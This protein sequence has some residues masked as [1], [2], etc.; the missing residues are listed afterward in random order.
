MDEHALEQLWLLRGAG[1]GDADAPV[2]HAARPFRGLR[3]VAELFFGVEHHDDRLR[4]I[5][6]EHL[7]NSPE[8]VFE[9]PRGLGGERPVDMA[10]KHHSESIDTPFYEAAIGLSIG[11]P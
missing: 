1:G 8:G 2:E 3:D 9:Q 7:A 11:P 6:A 10:L 5:H 4:R